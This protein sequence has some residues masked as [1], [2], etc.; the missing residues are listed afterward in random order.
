MRIRKLSISN[1]RSLLLLSDIEDSLNCALEGWEFEWNVQQMEVNVFPCTEIIIVSNRVK[2]CWQWKHL[3]A[4]LTEGWLRGHIS[5]ERKIT[6]FKDSWK[7]GIKTSASS[8]SRSKSKRKSSRCS[9]LSLA[10]Q[11]ETLYWLSQILH[12]VFYSVFRATEEEKGK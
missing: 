4:C 6:P 5:S 8:I 11:M 2:T 9:L 10:D 3:D 7:I 12:V 1:Y